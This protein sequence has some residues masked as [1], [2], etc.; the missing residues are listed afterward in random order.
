MFGYR[1]VHTHV[2]VQPTTS[3]LSSLVMGGEFCG[4]VGVGAPVLLLCTRVDWMGARGG[5]PTPP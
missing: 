5:P 4:G 3:L 1:Y 2:S